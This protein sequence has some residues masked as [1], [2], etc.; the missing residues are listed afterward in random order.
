MF[1]GKKDRVMNVD[2]NLGL[3]FSQTEN[4]P[5]RLGWYVLGAVLGGMLGSIVTVLV[6]LLTV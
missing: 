4:E 2:V 1:S 5:T 3:L 6:I